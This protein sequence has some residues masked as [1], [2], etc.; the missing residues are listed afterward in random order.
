MHEFLRTMGST[1][2]IL[3]DNILGVVC[4]LRNR[5][6]RLYQLALNICVKNLRV[7]VFYLNSFSFIFLICL[8]LGWFKIESIQFLSVDCVFLFLHLL[9]AVSLIDIILSLHDICIL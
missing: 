1:I 7:F 5:I 6:R 4:S 2:N 9:L 3:N 8:C